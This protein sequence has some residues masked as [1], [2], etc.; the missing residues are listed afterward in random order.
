MPF[1]DCARITSLLVSDLGLS[2]LLFLECFGFLFFFRSGFSLPLLELA[3]CDMLSPRVAERARVP[4]NFFVCI[5]PSFQAFGVCRWAS[6]RILNPGLF[7]AWIITATAVVDRFELRSNLASR[8][9]FPRRAACVMLCMHRGCGIS[10]HLTA[11]APCSPPPPFRSSKPGQG[12][13]HGARRPLLGLD[14]RPTAEC[15][16]RLTCLVICYNAPHPCGYGYGYIA[17]ASRH[18]A[19]FALFI[20]GRAVELNEQVSFL[21]VSTPPHRILYEFSDFFLA[22]LMQFFAACGFYFPFSRVT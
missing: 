21:S 14:A 6:V 8:S 10:P 1:V 22:L 5:L 2:G 11:G 13:T 7:G 17:V 12:Y 20:I 16:L 18:F 9:V 15:F 4:L 3:T 19:H